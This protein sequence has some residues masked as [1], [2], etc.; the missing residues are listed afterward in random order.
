[1][2]TDDVITPEEVPPSEE[3]AC[4]HGFRVHLQIIQW[5]MLDETQ[6]LNPSNW[7]CEKDVFL[8][9]RPTDKDVTPAN[10]LKVIKCR[11]KSTSEIN[12]EPTS[13]LVKRMAKMHV[14]MWGMPWR[15][16]Q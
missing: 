10:I 1:M 7:G 2:I 16:L 4:Y 15:R 13:V 8:V 12:V 3:A 14:C 6:S 5:K 9:Q 11:C